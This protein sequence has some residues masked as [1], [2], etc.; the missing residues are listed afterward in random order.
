MKMPETGLYAITHTDNKAPDVVAEEVDAAIRGGAVMVQYRDKEPI[1]AQFLA[2]KLLVICLSHNVPL[3]IND[4]IDLAEKVGAH[5]VHLGKDDGELLEARQRLGKDA[6]IGVSCY[7]SID[8]ALA[9]QSQGASYVAFGRFFPSGSKPLAAPANIETLKEARKY[10]HIPIIA[11]GGILPDNG[12]QLLDAGADILSSI[13][14]VF[15]YQPEQA[16]R[17]YLSLFNQS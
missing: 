3:L 1:D 5:G 9:A 2:E 14:G 7:N 13:G 11:V 6:I 10:I 15:D 12:K 4:D 16:A 17:A 8:R